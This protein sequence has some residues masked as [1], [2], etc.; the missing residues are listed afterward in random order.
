MN[1]QRQQQSNEMSTREKIDS[2]MRLADS[3]ASRFDR[4]REVEWKMVFAYW[5]IVI[6]SLKSDFK[7]LTIPIEAW[8]ISALAFIVV[9][10]RG[11]W[12][13]NR[14][15]KNRYEWLRNNATALLLNPSANWI[16]EPKEITWRRRIWWIDFLFDW[17]SIW[18]I[19][20][21][22]GLIAAKHYCQCH[23]ATT[24]G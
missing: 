22:L 18:Q 1:P 19:A 23:G 14:K 16:E 15:D 8:W 20:V 2:C 9:Y 4:R 24:N 12:V 3:A 7:S 17:N 6:L 13:A 5:A 21:T 10:L 11:V